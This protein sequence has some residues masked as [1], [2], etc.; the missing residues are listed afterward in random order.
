MKPN[1]DSNRINDELGLAFHKVDEVLQT[2]TTLAAL[3][4]DKG[5]EQ[6][7]LD[8]NRRAYDL[9]KELVLWLAELTVALNV[10]EHHARNIANLDLG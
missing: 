6:Y 3:L 9:N 2:F 10:D 4:T 1:T 5:W 8:M 7:A